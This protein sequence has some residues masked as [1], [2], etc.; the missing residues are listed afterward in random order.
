MLPGSTTQP[1]TTQRPVDLRLVAAVSLLLSLWLILIKPVINRDAILYLRVADAYL[2][3]GILASFA[4]FDRPFL[5]IVMAETHNLTGFS[6]LHSGLLLSALFYALLSIVFVSIVQILGGDRRTQIIATIFVLS[7]P[8]LAQGRD[9]IMRDPPYWAFVLLAFRALLLYIRLPSFKYQLQWFSFISIAS[10]FRFEGLF[11]VLLSPLAVFAA[12]NPA[13]RL[14]MSL[15]LFLLPLLTALSLVTAI[16]LYKPGVYLDT[17]LF[18]D[19]GGYINKLLQI[20]QVFSERALATGEA[21]LTHYSKDDAKIVTIAALTTVLLINL[22]RAI[23]WPYVI[24]LVWGYRQKL[25]KVISQKDR[26]LLNSHLIIGLIY[27]SIF[28]LI[29]RFMLERYCHIFTIFVAL[30]LPFILSF[31]CRPSSKRIT[32]FLAVLLLAGMVID[33]AGNGNYKK[34]FIKDATE[35]IAATLPH[36]NSLISNSGY[37]GYFSGLVF[38]WENPINKDFTIDKLSD[39]PALWRQSDYLVVLIMPGEENKWQTLLKQYS[40]I[41]LKEFKSDSRG[42]LSIVKIPTHLK[43]AGESNS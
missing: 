28:T 35:W 42:R 15:R 20:P 6:L 32:K 7:H 4:L 11:F 16:F 37:I 19:I 38:D 27:L 26:K 21:L 10:F 14:Q 31:A 12:L 23:M 34:A 18:S 36:D 9:S 1:Y 17:T 8:L 41:E 40:L 13:H 39:K 5:S 43:K 25:T 22:C 33:V 30:H 3:D 24:A 2:Q 29:N